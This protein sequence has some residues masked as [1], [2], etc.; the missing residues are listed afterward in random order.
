MSLKI[1][2]RFKWNIREALRA[3]VVL[4]VYHGDLLLQQRLLRA[5][6]SGP[7]YSKLLQVVRVVT[8]V[9]RC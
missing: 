6:V 8:E 7:S 5:R 1:P 2:H 4:E 3:E 9:G